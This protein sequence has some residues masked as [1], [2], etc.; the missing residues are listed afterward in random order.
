MEVFDPKLAPKHKAS[1]LCC[2]VAHYDN[3]WNPRPQC[4]VCERCGKYINSWNA[5]ID[6]IPKKE[7]RDGEDGKAKR[8]SSTG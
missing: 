6:C 8:V 4:F 1:R 2:L 3:N 5:D 7:G